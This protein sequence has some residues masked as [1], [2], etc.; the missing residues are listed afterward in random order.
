[1]KFLALIPVGATVL[2]ALA[3]SLS[4]ALVH[5][6]EVGGSAVPSSEPG[7]LSADEDSVF[8]V[9]PLNVL[10]SRV[11]AS[12]L[13]VQRGVGIMTAQDMASLPGR[14][15]PELLQT[16]PSVVTGRR[17]PA[18]VQSDLSIRGSTFEQVQVLLDGYDIGDP[19]T[20]HHVLNLPLGKVDIQ[21][22]EM[23]PGHGSALYGSGAFGGTVNVVTRR[24]QKRNGGE[25]ALTGGGLGIWGARTAAEFGS[26]AKPISGRVS[27]ERFSYDGPAAAGTDSDVLTATGALATT[28]GGGET[29]LFA[30]WAAREFG[31]PGFYAP[32]PSWE[33][34]RTF[35]GAIRHNRMYGERLTLEPRIFFR[36]HE[37]RFVLLRE[38][39]DEYTNDH[40]T[41]K[42]GSEL[43][44]IL[45]LG[46]M[47]AAAVAVEGVYEDIDSRGLRG[48]IWGDALGRHN[49][50]RVSVAAEL[51]HGGQ[52]VCWQIGGR[53]D[54]RSRYTPRFSGT[55]SISLA[56]TDELTAHSSAGTVY[57]VPTFTELYYEGG[58]NYGDPGLRPEE[59]WSWDAG[60]RWRHKL[61]QADVS[62]FERHEENLIEWVDNA[63][64]EPI[65]WRVQ[66][67]AEGTVR[68]VETTAAWRHDDG[69]VLQTGWTWLEKETTLPINFVGKY[70]LLTPRH[71]LTGRSTMVL[72]QHLALTVTGR[73]IERTGGPEAFRY[74]FL[75]DAGLAWEGP[76]GWFA[77]LAGT[78]LLDRDFEEVPGVL[79][80]G[81]LMTVTTGRRF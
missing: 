54:A 47:L 74:S 41:R 49:R 29:E 19:Q 61:L 52:A 37:D 55:T 21:R 63:L 68:G 48:G 50:R 62:F 13:G 40:A 78:N 72:P 30:G 38:N 73:Y 3:F 6:A 1:M 9:E 80:P 71:V 18:G 31:A 67:I 42:V 10:G 23:L 4:V 46:E 43:R 27:L 39:A 25:A 20:G 34:T 2:V 53:L 75:L 7:F 45:D 33:R 11:P 14:G 64:E 57:R 65:I 5:G 60:L 28:A 24:P 12:L 58:N 69:H 51:D 44:G 35:F 32:Y 36:R 76:S 16:M 59:G 81:V 79:M 8:Q 15:I 77:A 17:S 26:P 22:L 70:A 66:N 56:L